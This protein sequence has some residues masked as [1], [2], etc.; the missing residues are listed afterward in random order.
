MY[1]LLLILFV[2]VAYCLVYG[3]PPTNGITSIFGGDIPSLYD[4]GH[5][6]QL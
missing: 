5:C 3:F 1:L 4:E 2:F 6:I